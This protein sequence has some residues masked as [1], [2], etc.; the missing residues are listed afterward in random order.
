[1]RILPKRHFTWREPK[2]F[3]TV[4]DDHE[5]STR[6]WWHQPLS[7]AIICAFGLL[8]WYAAHF[9]PSRH[10]PSFSAALAMTIALGAFIAYFVPW[11]TTKLPSQITVFDRHIVRSRGPA[12]QI[13]FAD[14]TSFAWRFAP[15]FTTLVFTHRRGRQIFVGVP[16][17]IP[18]DSLSA[19]LSER[20]S[21][22]EPN[23]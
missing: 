13:R 16:L 12:Q 9:I 4:L 5:R 15:E 3:L 6:R 11:L 17:D 1:M 8:S 18:N 7:V 21:R 14:L 19:F 20:L 22:N 10:P 23:A 2:S